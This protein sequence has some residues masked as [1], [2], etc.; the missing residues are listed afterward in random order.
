MEGFEG[1]VFFMIPP[2]TFVNKSVVGSLTALFDVLAVGKIQ[3]VVV[4]SSTGIYSVCNEDLID[5][6]TKPMISNKRVERP[7]CKP[8]KPECI[9]TRLATTITYNGMMITLK[10]SVALI[11]NFSKAPKPRPAPPL[12]AASKRGI[13]YKLPK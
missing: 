5:N 1:N 9:L 4:A 11:P 6:S 7:D 8:L 10:Q 13:S 2:S 3:A 12:K